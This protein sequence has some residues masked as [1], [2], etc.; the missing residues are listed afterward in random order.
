M[1]IYRDGM[2]FGE[3]TQRL[4]KSTQHFLKSSQVL[5]KEL[6]TCQITFKFLFDNPCIRYLIR[7]Y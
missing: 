4:V 3:S 1:G 2:Y 5:S 6:S 7:I